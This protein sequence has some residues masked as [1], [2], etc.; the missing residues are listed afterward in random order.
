MSESYLLH[1]HPFSPF[2]RKLRL[3]LN[4][5]KVEFDLREERY[6]E[7]QPEFLRL[8]PAGQVPVLRSREHVYCDSRAICEY[9]EAK[10]P[11]PS[12]FP[13]DP[14]E[15]YEVR[16]LIA[17]FDERFY[18][19][20]TNRLVNE[21]LI[22]HV[23]RNGQPDGRVIAAGL[24]GLRVHMNYLA[25]LLRTTG[26]LVGRRLTLADF[27]A[28][29]H[30]SCIDYLGDIDWSSEQFVNVKD[31][32]AAIKSRPAFRPLLSDSVHGYSASPHYSVLDF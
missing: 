21:K 31:W 20:V 32:Y 30:V 8:N 18:T 4:E 16:R 23:Q 24:R 28:A 7:R 3:T 11:D 5:K 13:E 26:W 17:W 27:T 6:W 22:R 9:L 2:C 25:H 10:F 12:L 14:E 1:H 29:A 15:Q 19:E